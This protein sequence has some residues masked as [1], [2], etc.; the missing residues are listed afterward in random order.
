MTCAEINPLTFSIICQERVRI[1]VM[2]LYHP[3]ILYY[4]TTLENLI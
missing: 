1:K 2:A 4:F 3:E